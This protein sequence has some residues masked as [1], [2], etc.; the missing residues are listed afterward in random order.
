MV[1]IDTNYTLKFTVS[2]ETKKGNGC[3][4]SLRKQSHCFVL[5]HGTVSCE[6]GKFHQI[7]QWDRLRMVARYIV[8]WK[9]VWFAKGLLG[10]ETN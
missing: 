6:T 1:Q 9:R 10:H 3:R 8:S 7:K 5:D 2:N 4:P